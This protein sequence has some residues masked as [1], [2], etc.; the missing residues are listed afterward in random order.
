[1]ATINPIQNGDSG[2]SV[3]T[4][5]NQVLTTYGNGNIFISGSHAEGL[6]TISSGSYSHSEGRYTIATGDY[7]HAEGNAT[8]A[9]GDFS[10]AEG[11]GTQA[12]GFASHAAGEET[13][14]LG[15]GSYA[16]GQGTIASGSLQHVIGMFNTRGD[17]TSLFIIGNGIDQDDISRSDAFKVRMSGSIIL[18]VTSSNTP[19]WT[20]TQG[21]MMFGDDGSGNF[22]L[23]A[24][25]GGQWR[26]GSLH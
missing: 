21:E 12:I 26:S 5:L 18:P 7:S 19:P 14:A 20:G 3:R 2:L 25:L 15:E 11:Y 17:A 23:W 24:Y 9:I 6:S 22:V 4:A 16:A 10:H 8:Q 13:V 1:M